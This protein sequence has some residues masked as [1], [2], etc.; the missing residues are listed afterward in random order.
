M[1]AVA[2]AVL[3]QLQV[4]KMAVTELHQVLLAHL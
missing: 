4:Q 2:V 3:A 1:L